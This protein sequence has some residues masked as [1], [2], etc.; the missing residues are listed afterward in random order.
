MDVDDP[1]TVAGTVAGSTNLH[2][3]P[4]LGV[5]PLNVAGRR[6]CVGRRVSDAEM[7]TEKSL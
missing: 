3:A 1:A 2:V 4:H 5:A 6:V 7:S